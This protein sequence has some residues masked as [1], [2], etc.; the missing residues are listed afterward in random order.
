MWKI[1]AKIHYIN[2]QIQKN[3]AL[4]SYT[5]EKQSIPITR[6][7]KKKE[8]RREKKKTRASLSFLKFQVGFERYKTSHYVG[9]AKDYFPM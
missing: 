5:G 3:A 4:E 9:E 8:R 2:T 6:N 7:R 1:I